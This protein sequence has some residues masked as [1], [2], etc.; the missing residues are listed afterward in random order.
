MPD[1]PNGPSSFTIGP[2]C[3]PCLFNLMLDPEERH[4]QAK[5]QPELTAK[6]AAELA[7]QTHFQTGADRYVGDFTH[8]VSMAN[9]TAA[10]QGFLGPL[11]NKGPAQPIPAPDIL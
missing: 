2:A 6:L 8:C 11:C 10:H 1:F 9:F 5:D 7:N 4:D 3:D